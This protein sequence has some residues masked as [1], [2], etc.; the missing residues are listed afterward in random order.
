MK[1]EAH[2]YKKFAKLLLYN[3]FTCVYDF[4]N[5]NSVCNCVY[6]FF[7]VC[8]FCFA[9]MSDWNADS[10]IDDWNQRAKLEEEIEEENR[11]RLSKSSWESRIDWES[12]HQ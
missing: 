1:F 3:F 10:T 4:S 6:I 7:R 11:V 8:F 9:T 12:G 5:H 2:F